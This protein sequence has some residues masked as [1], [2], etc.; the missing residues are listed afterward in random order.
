MQ[1]GTYNFKLHYDKIKI[2]IINK[3]YHTKKLKEDVYIS[4]QYNKQILEKRIPTKY[5]ILPKKTGTEEK[6]RL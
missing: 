5:S 6:N 4:L 3:S 2:H 1:S